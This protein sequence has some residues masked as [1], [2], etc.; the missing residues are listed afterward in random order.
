MTVHNIRA[1]LESSSNVAWLALLT[2][3]DASGHTL[4]VVNN[5]V[6]VVSRGNTFEPYPFDVTLPQDDSEQLPSVS[7]VISNLDAAIIEYVRESIEPPGIAIELVTSQYPDQVEVSLTF[8]RLGSVTYDAMTVS[9]QLAVDNFLTQKF[10]A[11][12]YDP[13]AFPALFR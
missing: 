6:A 11:E 8:L 12:A 7:L 3:T 4:R 13:V 5:S 2:I 10:P 9:G 1:A